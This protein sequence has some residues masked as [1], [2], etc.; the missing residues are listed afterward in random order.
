[1]I[2]PR[3]REFQVYLFLIVLMLLGG[4]VLAGTQ[5]RSE[6]AAFNVSQTFGVE[7]KP[8]PITQQLPKI[9]LAILLDTSN[10]M[11][12]LIDQ[13]RNQ[14]W[15]AVNEFAKLNR[16]GMTPSLEV[17]VYEYGND[18][19][20]R[21]NGYIRQVTPFTRELD[22]V[23][24][25][26]FALTTNGGS[27]Y[28]GYVIDMATNEL[29]WSSSSNDIKAIFIAG[30]EPFTQGPVK[31]EQA[32]SGSNRKGITVHTIHAGDYKEGEQTGW[33]QGALLAG[34]NYM[35]IDANQRIVHID[36][37]QD[38]RISELN[39]QLNKTYVPYGAQGEQKAQR[40]LEQDSK[41]EAVSF[42]LLAKRARSKASSLYNNSTWDL[43][44]A[45]QE[46]KV[47][48]GQL[49]EDELPEQMR[50]MDEHKRAQ[51]VANKSQERNRLKQEIA[52]LSKARD[53]YVAAQKKQTTTVSANTMN[54]ALTA[55]VREQGSKKG[56]RS[57][58]Q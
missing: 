35:S 54:D 20:P 11:D 44:D 21:Q 23:S 41:S 57:Q 58:V 47:K 3:K 55:A 51:Y 31:F 8:T 46:G 25:A 26:L 36:A 2:V 9:Q 38:K 48:M 27:E 28:C 7:N 49:K 12:G 24:E 42:G 18:T 45:L 29:H 5:V 13:A 39:A 50:T 34:G 4:L 32:I 1:M 16:N 33:K 37:P 10:S 40:Q 15:Q 56:F 52:D 30:N 53:L 22:Q 14:L 17:A 43:V 6:E 19:L